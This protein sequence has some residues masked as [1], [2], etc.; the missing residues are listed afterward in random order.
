MSHHCVQLQSQP[1]SRDDSHR[2]RHLHRYYL[3]T[4]E[5]PT[6]RDATIVLR[7]ANAIMYVCIFILSKELFGL[8]FKSQFGLLRKKQLNN[9]QSLCADKNGEETTGLYHLVLLF[10]LCF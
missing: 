1:D 6:D 4:I 10:I 3:Y 7:S 5:L 2:H 9:Q 8:I